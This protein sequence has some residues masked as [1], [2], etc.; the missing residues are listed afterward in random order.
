MQTNFKT[1]APYTGANSSTLAHVQIQKN[2]QHKQWLTFVQARQL[3]KQI[4]KGEKGVKLLRVLEVPNKKNKKI[5]DKVVRSFFVF[6]V[7]QVEMK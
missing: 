2:Y 7:E 1:K 4:R 5:K 6:N 3:G